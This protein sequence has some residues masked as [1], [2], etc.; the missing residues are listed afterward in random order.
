MRVKIYS[1]FTTFCGDYVLF[2][3]IFAIA[4]A[5][6]R[7]KFQAK[8]KRMKLPEMAVNRYLEHSSFKIAIW[9]LITITKCKNVVILMI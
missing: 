1:N 7:I 6:Q 4:L 5:Q 3:I 9:L 2:C 8:A